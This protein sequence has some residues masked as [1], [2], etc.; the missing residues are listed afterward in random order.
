MGFATLEKKK[1]CYK[2]C[3]AKVLCINNVSSEQKLFYVQPNINKCCFLPK[4]KYMVHLF[5]FI[6][7]FVCFA[8]MN[9]L[10]LTIWKIS[11]IYILFTPEWNAK[12]VPPFQ[13]LLLKKKNTYILFH[14]AF[15][16]L[17]RLIRFNKPWKKNLA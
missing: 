2:S 15:F 8:L 17:L 14:I 5:C 12:N 1:Y 7:P 13:M 6:V 11:K 3:R 16:L 10:K 9:V 4:K